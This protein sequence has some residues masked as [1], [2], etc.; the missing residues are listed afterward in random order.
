MNNADS[1]HVSALLEQL[2]YQPTPSAEDADVIV[3]NTCMVRQSAEDKAIGRLT[4]LKKIKNQ[5]PNVVINLM[6]CLVGMGN[7]DALK[8]RFPYVDVFSAP[9]DAE[10]L[11]T[12]LNNQTKY[13]LNQ[14]KSRANFILSNEKYYQL[15]FSEQGKTVSVFVPVL[16][17]CSHSCSYCVIPLRRGHEKSRPI[18][19]IV[20]EVRTLVSKG[21]KEVTLLGQIVDRYGMDQPGNQNLGDLLRQLH[22]IDG[23]E[24]IRFLTSHPLWMTDEMLDCVAVLP[25]VMPYFELPIQSGDDEVLRNMRRGYTVDRFMQI[26]CKIRQ[27]F[28]K[29]SL[30]TDLIV[31]FPGETDVQF[32]NTLNLINELKMDMIHV[33]RYS[34]RPGTLAANTMRDDISLDEKMHR[35]RLIEQAHEK[36]VAEINTHYLSK[37][38]SVLFEGK[39]KNR[40]RGR[41]PTN[42]IVF[43]ETDQDLLGQIVDVDIQWTGPWS[44]IATL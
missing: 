25:K 31:G 38:V 22:N 29:A 8:A 36:I 17:G 32:L 16:Y 13:L 37:K 39:V 6:G 5:N 1:M 11:I 12:Y 7:Q 30:A 19:D 43:V 10:A 27:R 35:F 2:G 15:P 41:S 14:E 23:L 18:Q 28:N 26:V 4:S 42:K 20:F 24:R 3:L 21:V 44:M 33:A 40:W 34:P 9:S